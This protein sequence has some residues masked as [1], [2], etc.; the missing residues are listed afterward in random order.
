M[1]ARAAKHIFKIHLQ[2]GEFILQNKNDTL[3]FG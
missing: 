3:N 1:I 2:S